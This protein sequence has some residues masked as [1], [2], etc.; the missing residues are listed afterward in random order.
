VP[1]LC[2]FGPYCEAASATPIS[3][4]SGSTGRHGGQ[5]LRRARLRPVL[6]R[7]RLE[8]D[9]DRLEPDRD[10]LELDRDRLDFDRDRLVLD[11]F[12]LELPPA[13]RLRVAAALRADAER[14]ALLRLAEARPPFRPPF[15]VGPLLVF[16]PR[17]EPDL[18]PPPEIAFSVAQA[19]RSASSLGTPRLS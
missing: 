2:T 17:P 3:L 12:A 15:F 1:F 16:R 6:F 5:R 9:R 14:A 8:P 7:D 18:R 13:L 10:R 11:R 4:N 19:R